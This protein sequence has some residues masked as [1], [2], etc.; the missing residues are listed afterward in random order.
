MSVLIK[1]NDGSEKVFCKSECL[2]SQLKGAKLINISTSEDEARS[3]NEFLNAFCDLS[4]FFVLKPIEISVDHGNSI[5]GARVLRKSKMTNRA[6]AMRWL[7]KELVQF[8]N[9]IDAKLHDIITSMKEA[10][11]A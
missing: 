4:T 7:V 6:M 9:Q 2:A 11:N 3:A 5:V 10:G 1:Y 8:H